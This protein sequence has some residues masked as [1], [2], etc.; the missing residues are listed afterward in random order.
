MALTE[1]STVVLNYL[2]AHMGEDL[3][4]ADIAA[5]VGYTVLSVNGIVTRGLTN[6]AYREEVTAEDG[7]TAKFIRLTADGMNFDPA[8]E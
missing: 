7:T 5:G 2:K 3:T 6:L 8:A 1:K 4:A